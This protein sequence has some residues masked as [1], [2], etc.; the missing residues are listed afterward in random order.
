V[1]RRRLSLLLAV[2]FV[3]SLGP[4]ASA[5]ASVSAGRGASPDFTCPDPGVCIFQNSDYTGIHHTYTPS[6]DG[7]FWSFVSGIFPPSG[8]GVPQSVNNNSG[9]AVEFYSTSAGKYRCVAP[10]TREGLVEYPFDYIYI[11]YGASNCDN[12]PAWPG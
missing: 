11:R 9:S 2:T 10:D 8:T 7:G 12:I 3:L 6:T 5:G 4:A 1:L